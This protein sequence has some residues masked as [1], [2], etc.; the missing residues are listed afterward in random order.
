MSGDLSYLCSLLASEKSKVTERKNAA[1]QIQSQ[2]NSSEVVSIIDNNTDARRKKDVRWDTIFNAVEVYV[3]K[4]LDSIGQLKSTLQR[5]VQEIVGFV[6]SILKKADERGPRLKGQDLVAHFLK[7]IKEPRY[8]CLIGVEY[9]K[10]LK[11]ILS[12]PVY[13]SDV[14]VETWQDLIDTFVSFME[15]IPLW[16]SKY[17][18]L[19]AIIIHSSIV[20]ASA[21]YTVKG[22]KIFNFFENIFKETASRNGS[23]SPVETF[24]S[25]LNAFTMSCAEDCRGQICHLGES[26]FPLLLQMWKKPQ[27][28]SST[29]KD[30]LIQFMRLQICAHHPFGGHNDE[31][32]SWSSSKCVE[33]LYETILGDINQLKNKVVRGSSTKLDTGFTP[34]FIELAA[35]VIHQVFWAQT[36]YHSVT[37]DDLSSEPG[38][39]RQKIEVGWQSCRETLENTNDDL[40]QLS[41]LQILTCLFSKH[42]S[43]LPVS[44]FCHFVLVLHQ[45]QT[46]QKRH[47][48]ILAV[49]RCLESLVLCFSKRRQELPCLTVNSV[50]VTF[51]QIWTSTLRIIGIKRLTD[52]A[53]SLLTSLL[54]ERVIQ[55]ETD[56]FGVIFASGTP[57][58]SAMEFLATF[59]QLYPLP[60]NFQPASSATCTVAYTGSYPLRHQLF[61]WI[62]PVDEGDG[63]SDVLILWS[64]KTSRLP[65]IHTLAGI[66]FCLTHKFTATVE[67][68]APGSSLFQKSDEIIPQDTDGFLLQMQEVYLKS[69]FDEATC[70]RWK[71][72]GDFPSKPPDPSKYNRRVEALCTELCDRLNQLATLLCKALE[73]QSSGTFSKERLVSF[74]AKIEGTVRF[75]RLVSKIMVYFLKN[76]S[77]TQE[78]VRQLSLSRKL[79]SVLKK[80]ANCLHQIGGL[81]D[82]EPMTK[83]EV[84]AG[85]I[86]ELDKCFAG[87]TS[88]DANRFVGMLLKAKMPSSVIDDIMAIYCG[89]WG[90][91]MS[92]N[93]SRLDVTERSFL[94]QSTS[95]TDELDGFDGF[96]SEVSSTEDVASSCGAHSQPQ[97][98]SIKVA[99]FSLRDCCARFLCT[100]AVHYGSDISVYG[101]GLQPNEIKEKLV[102]FLTSKEFNLSKEGDLN[103]YFTVAFSLASNNDHLASA[104]LEVLMKVF[105]EAMSRYR[106]DQKICCQGLRLL[107]ALVPHLNNQQVLDASLQAAREIAAHMRMA[108]WRL[109]DTQYCAAVR[110]Q[111]AKY[112]ETLLKVDPEETWCTAKDVKGG[113]ANECGPRS[114]CKEFAKLLGDPSH[115]IRTHMA[116]AIGVLFVRQ[117]AEPL[118]VPAP[119]EHQYM[120]FDDIAKILDESLTEAAAETLTDDEREDEGVNRSSSMLACLKQICLISP[121]CEK[122]AIALLF[123]AVNEQFLDKDLVKKVLGQ[124]GSDLGY[125]SRASYVESHLEFI[126]DDWLNRGFTITDFPFQMLDFNSIPEFFQHHHRSILSKL[127]ARPSSVQESLALFGRQVN[128]DGDC[129]ELI[130][131][132]FC[133]MT[134]CLLPCFAAP[135]R[136]ADALDSMSGDEEKARKS[137]AHL[138]SILTQGVC[139]KILAKK[140]DELIVC[141]L[142]RMYEP[143]SEGSDISQFTR[144]SDPEPEPPHFTSHAITA[145]F[146]FLTKCHGGTSLVSVLCNHKDNIQKI[147]LSLTSRIAETHLA[148]E[149]RRILSM[150]RLF[151]LL[152]LKVLPEGLGN[153]WAFFVRDV[154]YSLLRIIT[155]AKQ[156]I[157]RPRQQQQ[158]VRFVADDDL[159]LPCCNL[160]Y[161]VCKSAVECCSEEFGSH[162]QILTSTLTPFALGEGNNAEQALQLLNFLIVDSSNDLREAIS[163]LD[164]FP[165]TAKFKQINRCSRNAV[166]HRTSLAEE[167][168]HFLQ[169]DSRSEPVSRLEGLKLLRHSFAEN[170]DQLVDLVGR[171]EVGVGKFSSS[172]VAD[173]VYDLVKLASLL[174]NFGDDRARAVQQEVANC[175]GEI[176]AVDLSTVSLGSKRRDSISTMTAKLPRDSVTQRNATIVFLLNGYLIDKKVKVV[177]AAASCLKKILATESGS[178]LLKK[179]GDSELKQLLWYLEPFRPSK[180]K[181]SSANSSAM[182]ITTTL[183][184]LE[185]TM[186]WIP[187]LEGQEYSHDQWITN[188]VC[189]LIESGLVQDEVLVVLSP[190]CHTKVEF[191]ERVFPYVIHNILERGDDAS[192]KTLS[193]Q[194]RIFFSYCNG[195][196]VVSSRE[197]SPLL[198]GP[199][200]INTGEML[201]VKKES[202]R[203]MLSVVTYLRTQNVAKRGRGQVTQWDNNFWLELD[204]LEVASA[205]QRCSAYFTALLYTEI[206]ADIER[207]KP[208]STLSISLAS[209]SQT[210][211]IDEAISPSSD[212]NLSNSYQTLIL[213]AYASIGEPDSVYGAGAGRLADVDSRIRTYMHEH[214]WGK[215][216]GACDLRMQNTRSWSQT[217]LLQ[218][219]KNFGLDHVMRIYLK[220]LSAENPQAAAEVAELQYE[221]AWRNCVWDLDTVSSVGTE[222]RQGFHQSLYSCLRSLHEEELELFQ[223]TLDSAKLQVMQ[224][225]AHVSL[226]SVQSVYPSLTRLQCLVELENFAQNIDSAE[227]NLVD[228]WEE[229][230]PLPD[231]DFE[232]LEPLLALRTSMLQTRVKVM[233]KDS[234]RPEDV[235][236]LAGAYKDFA[237]HLE[238]QAKMARQ[239]NNPQVAEKAL[240]RIRQLQSGIAA[241]QTRLEGEDLGVSW[242]WK[243]EEAKLRWAR[244]EQDTAMFLLRSLGKHLEKVSDQSSEASRLY[245]QALGLYGNWLAESKS[246]NPNTII[247]EYLKKAA[248]LMECMEDGE[249]ASRIES[250]LSLAWFADTQYQK[251]VNFMSSSTYENKETLMR[252]SKVESE[253]LQ[254]VIE[255]QKDRYARTLNLQAQMDERELRQVFEDRQAFLKTA[256]EYYIKTLQTGDKYDLRIFRLCSL[257]FDNANEEF[258]SK[259]IKEGLTKI[260]SRKCLPLMYQLAARL[261]TKSH[262][263]PFFQATL[264]EVIER[265]A[266]DHPHHTLFILFALANAEKDTKYLTTGRKNAAS[267]RLTRRNSKEASSGFTE[268]RIQTAC[269]LIERI[270]NRRGELVKNMRNLCVAYIELAY[271]NVSQFKNERGPFNLPDVTIKRISNLREVPVPTLDVKVDPL[272]RYDDL[273]H[274]VGFDSKFCLAGGVNL[275]KIIF[276][277][278]SDGVKRRQLVKGRDD[279]RQDAVMEQVFGMVNQLLMKNSETRKRKLKMRTYKV[280]PLSQ[281]SGIVEWCEDTVPLG[282]YL[283]GRPGTKAGAHSRY[284]PGD[285][286]SLDCRKKVKVG[287]DSGRPRFEVYQELMEHF[288]PVFRHF[289]LEK[290]PDPAVWFERRLTYTRSVAISSIVGYIV[291]LG[292]RHVQNILVDCNTAEL[293]HIDL[294]VAFEQGKFLPTPETV[295]FR[296]TRDLVDGM[297]LT[298]VEGVYRRCCEKTMD[299]MR[300]S[301]ES[302]MTIVEVLLY[303]PLSS[304][305]LSPEKRKELQKAEE[306]H[307]DF[308]P[309]NTTSDYLDGSVMPTE[310]AA[311]EDNVNKMA[312]R[313]LLRLKQKLDGVEDGVHLS[314]S[315]QV[316]HLIREAM[317][318]KN[319]CRLFPGWQPWV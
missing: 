282:E 180:K 207:S 197:S 57:S 27:Q 37:T 226:E 241:I 114:L 107:V 183:V 179:F 284:Y 69:T 144:E 33:R 175:L 149:K 255:S 51:K 208:D 291:G 10:L 174:S 132:S 24:L 192:R 166:K 17:Q 230:F 29:L 302:L 113:A 275:P 301:Q 170:K 112:V 66:L 82:L 41:W 56:V 70:Q 202:V 169:A 285:W 78:E 163:G 130:A 304:W 161:Y 11:N 317:D 246:E 148:H 156:V 62:L 22:S 110:L 31:E 124:L 191:A 127:V 206:W 243:M 254:R 6:Q 89:E 307:C 140:F 121:I 65:N 32:G 293:V 194:F 205:A 104:H 98:K 186:L 210:Q 239:S 248:C 251:K 261:G 314:V 224:E 138:V 28:S 5:R 162:L 49:L 135:S 2:L 44:E 279:L 55:P 18:T 59:L 153:T 72:Q 260:Q 223:G 34:Q 105:R 125:A 245:P 259:M 160:L 95:A 217:G 296:L 280:I 311:L 137:H 316:N 123:Q 272:C 119:R 19:I 249:Q 181:R 42:I 231:N 91:F 216:L 299:V 118:A 303:D 4:E 115:F 188:L 168:S 97:K 312:K 109:K 290:F 273:V 212:G 238:M 271:F 258:V 38:A 235:M 141:L 269:E 190:I 87:L 294:G 99:Q 157:K 151:V 16:L 200:S 184:R 61:N 36:T 167:I 196:S 236:K 222:S 225:V 128:P 204:Y 158:Q 46:K 297:G 67:I 45:I 94:S 215:A 308:A 96:D 108:F 213:E 305:T 178:A 77:M 211:A 289:F 136:C 146:D 93:S 219:M 39:K 310:N 86:A 142:L 313:M 232:F 218:S 262:D 21:L 227:T 152:L 189:S 265:T 54:K 300:T 106:K 267:S 12:I 318:P 315:G 52:C 276:C 117:T 150:Y 165:D 60:E 234:D 281:R 319:L 84:V 92:G 292:D 185:D 74:G 288:R 274:V 172:I 164:P 240:F 229:R 177:T 221:S 228:V 287:D 145:T 264:N 143:P 171:G 120:M 134:A 48:I 244:G 159:F 68:V 47:E 100:W 278:G 266:V 79:G 1:R 253:R 195:T 173:L 35:D 13:R 250:F 139:D 23:S 116:A 214:A 199:P 155:D 102:D 209:N 306:D 58:R 101:I 7:V 76:N 3:E 242:S 64:N 40:V 111:L 201:E 283:I 75:C 247:E 14:R 71:Y 63:S 20:G 263:N 85:I 187:G 203:T 198:T 147:L 193:E 126:I 309:S 50:H 53:F 129:V 295:P 268:A 43:S 25:A 81:S 9:C 286:T 252:K 257:W 220:G 298:G 73:T 15:N 176:G 277:I 233:S 154:V 90:P 182:E 237:V 122:R 83:M 270:G 8:N 103:L 131:D 30:R 26:L 256:V 133:H 80:I 88:N